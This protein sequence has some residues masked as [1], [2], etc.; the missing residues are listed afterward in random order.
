MQIQKTF[1]KDNNI[2]NLHKKVYNVMRKQNSA[3]IKTAFKCIT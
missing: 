2:I 1:T 3:Q